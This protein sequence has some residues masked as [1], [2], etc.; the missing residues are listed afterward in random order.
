MADP[1]WKQKAGTLRGREGFLDAGGASADLPYRTMTVAEISALPVSDL[2]ESDAHLYLWT[3]NRYLEDAFGV[4]RAWGFNYST[5]IVWDKAPIGDGLGGA[6]G[7]N[8]EFCLFCKRGRLPAIGSVGRTCFSWKRR[9]KNGHPQHSAKPVAAQDQIEQISPG[10]Y[11]EL[12]ARSQRLGW[13]SWG[14]E[15]L[16][17]VEIPTTAAIP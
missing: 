8:T 14:N 1:P 12:F 10:P 4:A 16:E 9:Y 5:T 2:A 17:H 13:D 11:L 3:T 6:W 7:I 15:A